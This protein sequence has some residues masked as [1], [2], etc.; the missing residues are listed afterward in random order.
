M[1]KIGVILFKYI[2]KIFFNCKIEGL[3]N[4]P[5]KKGV[6]IAS[7]H[8][9]LLDPPLIGTFLPRE[10]HFM[11]KEELF[12]IPVFG[13]I[14]TKLKAFPVKRGTADRVAIKKAISLLS[15]GGCL[16]VFPE[17][18][19]SN[20]GN[21]GSAE[22]GMSLI[23]IKADV[24]VIPTAVV[25]ENNK[26]LGANIKIKFGTPISYNKELSVKDAMQNFTEEIMSE[27]KKLMVS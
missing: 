25:I 3:E 16:G 2:F 8:V 12:Q 13:Y 18:T 24:P 9:S 4:I 27:I 6:V 21:L 20:D 5:I 19:R 17:G 15:D 26:I 11:A 10:I 1:Y 23:A 7:N 22:P 14:I